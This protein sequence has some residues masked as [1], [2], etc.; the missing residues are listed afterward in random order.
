M[1]VVDLAEHSLRHVVRR[2]Y[3]LS[4]P[5]ASSAEEPPSSRHY[6]RHSPDW[7]A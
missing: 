4:Q 5:N 6:R 1:L 7:Q 2:R 3:G